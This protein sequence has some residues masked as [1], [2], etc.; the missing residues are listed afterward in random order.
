MYILEVSSSE[1]M[2]YSYL[3]DPTYNIEKLVLETPRC[4]IEPFRTEGINFEELQQAFVA[5]NEKLYVNANNP[6]VEEE[7]VFINGAIGNRIIGKAL[8]CYIFDRNTGSLIGSI[9]ISDLDTL[10][11]NLGLWIRKEYH[12]QGYGIEVYAAFLEWAR[13]TTNFS[14]FKHAVNPEN[15]ASIKLAEHFK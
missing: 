10:E 12:G 8:E 2:N 7:R 4:R 5:A 15:T 3:K 1:L 14:F 13:N 11:P 9:G 6:T